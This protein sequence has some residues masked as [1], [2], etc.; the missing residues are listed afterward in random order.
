MRPALVKLGD[1]VRE[2]GG[3]LQTGPFGSQLKQ[4][5]YSIEGVPVI[6][7]KD[8]H[9][10]EVSIDSVARVPEATAD[11][12]AR[13]RVAE[14]AIVLPRRG[15]VTKRAFITEKQA[16]WLCGT[17]CLKI[18]TLGNRIWPKY[19]YYYM[20]TPGAIEWL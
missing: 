14:N 18:E 12:L 1:A 20:G 11:R 13:H 3:I 16:G 8:I 15:E 4:A 9:N 17:G 7:P 19:L 6:M 10:G 5:E 2:D